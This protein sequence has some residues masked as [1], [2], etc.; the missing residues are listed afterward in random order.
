VPKVDAISLGGLDLRFYSS[1]HLPPHF[2]AIRPGEWNIRV[3]LR[4][5]TRDRLDYSMKWPKEGGGP[6]GKTRRTLRKLV[7][8]NR[9]ALLREWEENVLVQ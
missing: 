6:S 8:E 3:Y 5:T 4:S 7:S 9:A 1:D 2:H